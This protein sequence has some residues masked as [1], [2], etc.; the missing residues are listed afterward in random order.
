MLVQIEY[1][2]S[3]L[4]LLCIKEH[5][6]EQL[7]IITVSKR[8]AQVV[9]YPNFNGPNRTHAQ[10]LTFCS[11]SLDH[12]K[13][14]SLSQLERSPAIWISSLRRDL[15]ELRKT[16]HL[17]YQ[18]SVSLRY[19]KSGSAFWHDLWSFSAPTGANC[20]PETDCRTYIIQ[21]QAQT[22][23]SANEG[24]DSRKESESY[25]SVISN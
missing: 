9:Q 11:C 18:T 19:L 8:W 15:K 6:T 20:I 23:S 21:W 16:F 1:L 13:E 25:S 10:L 4:V 12:G 2:R 22:T 5:V 14:G 7:C 3:I 24:S 17:T